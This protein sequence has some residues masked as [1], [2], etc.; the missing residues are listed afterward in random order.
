MSKANMKLVELTSPKIGAISRATPVIIPIAAIEQHGDHLPVWTD[1]LLLGEIVDR[2]EKS[3]GKQILVAPLMWL[4]NS[5]HH[6]DFFGTLSASSRTYLDMLNDL[7]ENFLS[8]GFK[9]IVLLNGHGGNDVPAKQALFEIRQRNRIRKDLL[10][11][12]ATYWGLGT[13]PWLVDP[14]IEQRD[15]G[16]ACE[17]E[18]SMVLTLRPDLVG[19]YKNAPVIEPGNA[20][21]PASR[22]WTTKDRSSIGHIGSPHLASKE[23]GDVLFNAFSS[24]VER[25]L[26]GVIGWDG[27]SWDG[28]KHFGFPV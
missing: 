8:Y 28:A 19:D 13:E 25:W 10:L 24:D 12:M 11:L 16:H 14:A 23:K 20:F 7:V 21:R 1:S 5:D 27:S 17:W 9:R 6:L 3:L 22:A 18:T 26:K 4:G 2:V 15:M